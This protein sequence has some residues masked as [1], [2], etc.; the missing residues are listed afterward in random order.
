MKKLIKMLSCAVAATFCCLSLAGCGSDKLLRGA[1]SAEEFSYQDANE[2]GFAD[3]TDSSDKF[4]AAFAEAVYS[5]Y[6]K[7]ENLAVSPV[8]VYM[9]LAM[10]AECADGQTREEILSALGISYEQLGANLGYLYRSL[11]E[12]YKSGVI[13][14]NNSVWVNSNT[15]VQEDCLDELSEKYFA[16][17]YSADFEGDNDGA[18]K[19]IQDYVRE[20]TRGLID[21]KFN[22]DPMTYFVLINTLYLKDSWYTNG[23]DMSFADGDYTF[24]RADG[25]TDSR[26]LLKSR[27]IV[28]RQFEGESF[29]SFYTTTAA[30]LSV[31]FLL[32]KEGYDLADVFTAQNIALV[33]SVTDYDGVDQENNVRYNTRCIFPEF[34]ASYNG[35][36]RGILREHFGIEALF[37]AGECDLTNLLERK[38]QTKGED[39]CTQIRH[40]A[41][42]NVDK[43]GI[44]GAAVTVIADGA[45][46]APAYEEVYLDFVVDRAFGY[47]V[48]DRYGTMLFTGVVNG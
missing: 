25:T 45:T 6:D 4:S 21:S 1:A 17:S 15:S 43:T 23:Q 8:S 40:V 3:I 28:G 33:N 47:I 10:A 27:Y 11:N 29:T 19:A 32:P 7:D 38:D 31:K 35:D 37:E 20:K 46:G 5:D 26:R 24:T 2:Q 9:A 16:D 18:N 13:N 42:L 36:V 22:L 30:G 34:S 44:E 14:A 48:S 39:Y 41:K 12:E